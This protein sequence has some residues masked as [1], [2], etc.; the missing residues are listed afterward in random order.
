MSEKLS[1]R[2]QC[3]KTCASLWWRFPF[4]QNVPS[5]R[6][7]L[8]WQ[9]HY[10]PF[11]F[12]HCCFQGSTRL[13]GNLNPGNTLEKSQTV[14][15]Q[16]APNLLH[17]WGNYFWILCCSGGISQPEQTQPPESPLANSGVKQCIQCQK[18]RLVLWNS[19]RWKKKSSFCSE[20]SCYSLTDN[21]V[22]DM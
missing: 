2:K 17:E 4:S 5:E 1:S 10:S 15:R 6:Q 21:K 12:H 11:N 16:P 3:K 20:L 7:S 18:S 19:P 9:N 13:S 22:N 8:K 14:T